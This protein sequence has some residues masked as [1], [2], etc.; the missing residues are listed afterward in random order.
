M[1]V[2]NYW[3]GI[4]NGK[5]QKSLLISYPIHS[6]RMKMKTNKQKI[7]PPKAFVSYNFEKVLKEADWI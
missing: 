6:V 1:V 2:K 7:Y 5:V 3:R 4:K